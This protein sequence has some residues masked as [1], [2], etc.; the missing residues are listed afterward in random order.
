MRILR[1]LYYSE[2][3]GVLCCG[4]VLGARGCFVLFCFVFLCVILGYVI[5]GQEVRGLG[6]TAIY[7]S[8]AVGKLATDDDSSSG[9]HVAGWADSTNYFGHLPT[10]A[11]WFCV[12]TAPSSPGP[13]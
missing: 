8:R 10:I 6:S 4:I 9:G 11:V 3:S 13:F 7:L 12:H 1:G 2:R 5:W